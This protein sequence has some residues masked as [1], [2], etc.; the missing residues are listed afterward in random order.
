MP[1]DNLTPFSPESIAAIRQQLAVGRLVLQIHDASF[2]SEPEED[3]GRGS[4][5]SRGADRFFRFAVRLGFDA[6][7]LGPRGMTGRGN[8]SPYDGTIFSRNPLDLPLRKLVDQGRLSKESFADLKASLP[9]G[10]SERVPYSMIFDVY[11]YAQAEIIERATEVDREAAREFLAANESWLV[12]DALFAALSVTYGSEAWHEWSHTPQGA[13]DQRLFCPLPGQ[14]SH[15]NDRLAELRSL[16]VRSIEDY[17]LIQWLLQTEHQALRTRLAELKLAVYG[18][19]QV[20]M[21]PQDVWA[22][23][24]LFLPGYRMGAPPSRTNPAGQP[25]GYSLF[26]PQKFGTLDCPGPALQYIRARIGKVLAECDGLRIDHPHGWVDPWVYRD[27]G[28]D[29]FHAVQH[30]ARLYSTPDDRDHELLARYAIVRP[31]QLNRTEPGYADQRISSLDD[32]QVA[33]YSLLFD[34]IRELQA[35]CGRAREVVAC[36]VLST[37]PYQV[38]RVLERHGLGRFRVT[39]KIR[40]ND[41]TDVYR[42]EQAKAEDWIMMGTHDTPPTWQLA[43]EWCRGEAGKHW[44]MYLAELIAPIERA[45]EL[46]EQIGTSPAELIHALFAAMLNSRARN[47]VVFF[48]DLFGLEERYNEPG[49]VADAN[50]CLRLPSNFEELYEQRRQQNAALDISRC[51]RMATDSQHA[52]IETIHPE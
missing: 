44:G 8:P 13:F 21:S 10:R 16:H 22:A 5:Y 42:V 43:K 20:G 7:Q 29:A 2:P 32:Q 37:L 35:A 1:I 38:G 23:Q 30:G 9:L 27:D 4:P 26:D 33:C 24:H 14:E 36:E 18:D 31:E 15:A 19:L 12:P 41:P 39:Q 6:I 51:L 11:R 17:A 48:P 45:S 50:W 49:V 3:L 28:A 47:V 25:W 40:H 34:T 46:A 52:A